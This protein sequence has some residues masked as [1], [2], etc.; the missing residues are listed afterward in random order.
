MPATS[1]GSSTPAPIRSPYLT[2]ALSWL[3]P[4]AGHFWLGRR[5]RGVIVFATVLVAFVIGALMRG[6]LFQPSGG[7]DVLS[8][9][10]QLG[11]FIAD[12]ASGLVYFVAVWFG[13]APPDQASHTADYGS[14]FIVMAGL[15]NLLAMVDA[16]EITTRQKD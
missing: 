9:L 13:Y 11:G 15:L 5:G 7:S 10:I 8:R 16:Y 4:G 3:I 2:V 14:K 6:P 12:L 1:I